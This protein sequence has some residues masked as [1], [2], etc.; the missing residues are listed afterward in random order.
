MSERLRV[1]F[2]GCGGF[3]VESIWPSLRYARVEIAYAFSRDLG[4]ATEVARR[5][6]AE[7]ATDR[8]EEVLA[9]DTVDA[10]FV[11]GPPPMQHELGLRAIESGKHL[12]VEKPPAMDLAGTR[13]LQAAAASRGVRVQVG[14]QKRFA[15]AYRLAREEASRPAFGGIRLLKVNYSHWQVQDWRHHLAVL[16]VHGLDLA[17]F[18]LGE[19]EQVQL[20][21]HTAAD[22][23]N[24]CVL[25]LSSPSGAA[26]VLNLSG[27]DPHVQEWVEIS[28]AG[29]LISVR[30][31]V[32]YRKWSPASRPA[33]SMA[34]NPGAVAVWHPEFAIPYQQA[35]SLWLQGYAGEVVAFADAL[36]A[37]EPVTP[38]ITD[39]VAA[40]ELVEAIAAAPDGPSTLRIGG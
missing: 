16:S 25:T 18:F 38:S 23:M 33:D 17:R 22:G 19:L 4:K 9:D 1:G 30:N 11:I 34:V 32:E 12:F 5:F 36:L 10:V 31:L 40:M 6:G 21:K 8:V 2:V 7:R 29:Q 37:G 28:G 39:C 15:T 13:E 14:F 35:D 24:I 3:A 27:T 20:L 26:A